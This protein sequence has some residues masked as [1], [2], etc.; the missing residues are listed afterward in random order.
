M[1]RGWFQLRGLRLPISR[2]QTPWKARCGV[3]GLRTKSRP[4]HDSRN[5]HVRFW[6]HRR[7]DTTPENVHSWAQVPIT[8]HP[9]RRPKIPRKGAITMLSHKQR[10][11]ALRSIPPERSIPSRNDLRQDRRSHPSPRNRPLHQIHHR[12]SY[13]VQEDRRGESTCLQQLRPW[14]TR[15]QSLR[16]LPSGKTH[17]LRATQ[18]RSRNVRKITESNQP[19][20]IS[21]YG[22]NKIRPAQQ[23]TLTV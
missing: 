18:Y 20:K 3:R 8:S 12:P 19:T 5:L 16:R 15:H 14:S 23:N 17:R 9:F 10:P 2:R 4:I 22:R 7:N 21:T 11:C 13:P 6:R 1:Y